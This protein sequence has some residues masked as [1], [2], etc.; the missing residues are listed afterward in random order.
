VELCKR[1]EIDYEDENL[2]TADDEYANVRK[3]ITSGFFY[4]AA[5]LSEKSGTYKPIKNNTN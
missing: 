4:N 2:S 1:V 3:T 5:K